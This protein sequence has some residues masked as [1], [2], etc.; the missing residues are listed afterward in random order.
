MALVFVPTFLMGATLPLLVS[1]LVPRLQNVGRSVGTLYYVNTLGAGASCLF[2]MVALFPWLGMR[3][4]VQV[5][6][7]INIAVAVAAPWLPSG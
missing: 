5:A 3:G 6:V 1:H 4:S 7:M 2:S